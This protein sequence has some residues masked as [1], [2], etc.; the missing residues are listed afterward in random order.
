[1]VTRPDRRGE[2]TACQ[3]SGA[4]GTD[5]RRGPGLCSHANCSA[6]HA[7][8]GHVSPDRHPSDT[9]ADSTAAVM[10]NHCNHMMKPLVEAWLLI[11][12]SMELVTSI[13]VASS[14]GDGQK[15]HQATGQ[16]ASTPAHGEI[17]LAD[18][19][20]RRLGGQ[21]H[22]QLRQTRDRRHEDHAGQKQALWVA[23]SRSGRCNHVTNAL[24]PCDERPRN[25]SG[26]SHPAGPA[27]RPAG[28][29]TRGPAPAGRAP[30]AGIG[31]HRHPAGPGG[32]E[33][34]A[35]RVRRRAGPYLDAS[36]PPP[37][38]RPAPIPARYATTWPNGSAASTKNATGSR[39]NG[40]RPA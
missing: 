4:P 13:A 37:P 10:T 21:R 35:G 18:A 25:L 26:G 8:Q 7:R 23:L 28:R 5:A 19:S 6:R 9:V 29:R 38:R 31:G 14:S 20:P 33:R 2:A 17:Q 27:R 32:D 22:G 39:R 11:P 36:R 30:H 34:S 16:A 15:V 40:T 12:I 3:V 1:M 24:K